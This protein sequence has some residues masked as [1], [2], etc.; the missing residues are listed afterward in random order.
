[1]ITVTKSKLTSITVIVVMAFLDITNAEAA[2]ITLISPNGGE[3]LTQGSSVTITW[4]Q[5]AVDHAA[6][7]YTT[8]GGATVPDFGSWFFMFDSDDPSTSYDWSI[9]ANINSDTLRIW[10]EGHDN[11]HKQRLAMDSSNSNLMIKPSCAQPDTTYPTVS[12]NSPVGG[13]TLSGTSVTISATASDNVGVVGVQFKLDSQNFGSEDTVSPYSTMM[14]TTTIPEGAHTITASARDAAGNIAASSEISITV[15]N[16]DN[17][18][19]TVSQPEASSITAS[20]ATITWGTN[21]MSDT[22]VE[23]GVSINYGLSS[24]LDTT[25]K[26]SHSIT[27]N[28]LNTGTTYHYRAKSRDAAGNLAASNDLTFTTTIVDIMPPT[29]SNG[30]PVGTL[31]ESTTST[32][33]SMTTSEAATCK[34][35][36]I[37]GIAYTSMQNTFEITGGMSHSKIISGMTN[38]TYYYYAKCIDVSGNANT[39]DLIITFGIA[40]PSPTASL[41]IYQPAASS[42]TASSATI[43][44]DTNKNSDS[45]IDYGLT[46]DYGT[47]TVV[48]PFLV[49][50]HSQTLSGLSSSTIYHYRLKS[51]DS[52][53][54]LATSNEFT[55]V[56]LDELL[57]SVSI[58]SPA[59]GAIVSGTIDI[60]LTVSNSAAFAGVQFKIDGDNIGP[61]DKTAP[62]RTSWDTTTSTSGKH[63]LTAVARDIYGKLATT[64]IIIA[65][66]NSPQNGASRPMLD[67]IPV[68]DINPTD[69]QVL[70]IIDANEVYLKIGSVSAGSS[71]VF[72]IDSDKTVVKKITFEIKNQ[73]T[74][75]ELKIEDFGTN[76]VNVP[77]SKNVYKYLQL[78]KSTGYLDISK[79]TIQFKVPLS[80]VRNNNIQEDEI[81]LFHYE[82]NLWEPLPTSRVGSEVADILYQ[83]T[84]NGFSTFAIGVREAYQLEPS[85]AEQSSGERLQT[86]VG[87]NYDLGVAEEDTGLYWLYMASI[88]LPLIIF[89]GFFQIRMMSYG[90][91]ERNL[92]ELRTYIDTN[93]R[94]G[95]TMQQ[96]RYTLNKYGID[97]RDIE[98]VTRTLGIIILDKN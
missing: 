11:G 26:T 84:T 56:T 2:A 48:D 27:L 34:Y 47:S 79:A 57:P 54:N 89:L 29:R 36:T 85:Q 70:E 13:A 46:A 74:S 78:T 14:D 64:Q 53:G 16:A 39:D 8:D 3:C 87:Q 73:V 98:E 96:I 62:Y 81:I 82:N 23:Y 60:A 58:T 44:W 1:M 32:T 50:S 75:A 61:E 65:V 17:A 93:L 95:Y 18:P 51:R 90:R 66:S 43:T 25:L 12:I 30:A 88:L 69:K 80:W 15:S 52:G 77:L 28:G 45:Q 91:R 42:I 9:P 68:S 67:D 94:K 72:P 7:Y 21:E 31:I 59:S 83:A 24:N 41:T 86:P 19:P 40:K 20:S 97:D 37:P 49:T 22:Q 55:F 76:P 71:V 10:A 33:L 92:I 35:S 63:T 4:T 5:S 38:G 6:I